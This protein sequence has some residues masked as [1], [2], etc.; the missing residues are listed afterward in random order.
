MPNVDKAILNSSQPF[1][2]NWL[3]GVD[4]KLFTFSDGNRKFFVKVV[5]SIQA[6]KETSNA[7]RAS[8]ILTNCFVGEFSVK[9]IVPNKV[10]VAEQGKMALISPF[11]GKDLNELS[12]IGEKNK[13]PLS[14]FLKA[15]ELFIDK[16]IRFDGFLPRNIFIIDNDLYLIDWEDASFPDKEAI[17]FD[18]LW[19][20]N[21]LLNWGYLF[22]YESLRTILSALMTRY[23]SSVALPLSKYEKV[24]IK[25]L[26]ITGKSNTQ[27]RKL[28]SEIVLN[29][30][31]PMLADDIDSMSIRP[32]DIAHYIADI[33]PTVI[34]VWHDVMAYGRRMNEEED[35]F[36]CINKVCSMI[37]KSSR[38]G[39]D[40]RKHLLIPIMMLVDDNLSIGEL[41][42]IT[43]SSKNIESILDSIMRF[44]K[45]T[46]ATSRYIRGTLD[47]AGVQNIVHQSIVKSTG[48]HPHGDSVKKIAKIIIDNQGIINDAP[49]T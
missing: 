35:Y 3:V 6:R 49:K 42:D 43:G 44:S 2:N 5:D 7:R 40:C 39:E 1:Q 14:H 41:I 28:T 29:A 10:G 17:G 34:D 12:Y 11:L 27:I 8:Q 15:I 18:Y 31:R 48:Y 32:N 16:G 20:I 13:M 25:M 23:P 46:C 45:K 33:F 38:H 24:F 9:V 37:A 19:Y 4:N 36:S 26:N 21:A 30:E 47:I 22:D